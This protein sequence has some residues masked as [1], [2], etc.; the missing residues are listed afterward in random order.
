VAIFFNKLLTEY[1]RAGFDCGIPELNGYLQ[2][3]ATQDEKRN[4]TR[5]FVLV[6]GHKKI[7]G[8]FTL[9]QYAINPHSIPERLSKKLPPNRDIPCTLLGR[10]A[11]DN[12]YKGLG[13]GRN[14]LYYAVKRTA[15]TNNDIASY[16][17]V[18]DAKNQNAKGFYEK[19]GFSVFTDDEMRLVMLMKDIQ[20]FI[21]IWNEENGIKG[22][23]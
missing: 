4:L 5:V 6:E 13:Y 14:L 19:F 11:I 20:K 3:H 21:N 2:K 7:V 23:R 18:V 15:D 17:L 22:T 16:G 12:S 8:Y 1:D 9:S 10:F